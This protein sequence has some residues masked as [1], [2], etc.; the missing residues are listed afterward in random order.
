MPRHMREIDLRFPLCLL[1]VD[2]MESMNEAVSVI[3]PSR[4]RKGLSVIE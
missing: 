4:N 2:D 3:R 1:T